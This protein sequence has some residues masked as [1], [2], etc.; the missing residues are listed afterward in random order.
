M[1]YNT[2]GNFSTKDEIAKKHPAI[3]PEKLA[4]DHIRSWSNKGNIILDPM[5]G[6]GTSCKATRKLNRNYIGI[7]ISAD[8]CKISR[9]RLSQQ[10]LL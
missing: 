1:K 3:F 7:D 4:E 2:G 8:Y 5:C 9:E 6:S 10:I